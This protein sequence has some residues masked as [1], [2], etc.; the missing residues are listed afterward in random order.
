MVSLHRFPRRLTLSLSLSL[1]LIIGPQII[2]IPNRRLARR[3]GPQVRNPVHEA[4]RDLNRGQP[5]RL[6]IVE[7]DD[8]AAVLLPVMRAGLA[9]RALA[10]ADEEGEEEEAG[11]EDADDDA[12]D[13]G[14]VALRVES[15]R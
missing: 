10:A 3:R 8:V 6:E 13:A 5:L 1:R 12:D 2:N 9:A 7:R 4:L 15:G 14:V 11:D